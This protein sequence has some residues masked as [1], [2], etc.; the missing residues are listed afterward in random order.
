[1]SKTIREDSQYLCGV[2]RAEG[3]YNYDNLEVHHIT[4]IKEDP[5]RLL[6]RDNLICLCAKHHKMA[7]NGEISED[8]L[9]KLVENM[10]TF[11]NKG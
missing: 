8:Y 2:C 11:S 1:M 9:R 4:K 5:G 10:E 3:V 6:D 7:D